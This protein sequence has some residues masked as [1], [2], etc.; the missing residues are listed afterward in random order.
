[1]N[2][3][4]LR[5]LVAAHALDALDADE[6]A[7]V[8]RH[9]AECDD[10]R[11]EFDEHVAVA[12]LIGSQAADTDVP[13]SLWRRVQAEIEPTNVVPLRRRWVPMI[14]AVGA[15]AAMAVLVVV[16]TTRLSSAQ[17]Q[18]LAAEE[19]LATIEDAVETGDWSVLAAM[20]GDTPG[21]RSVTLTGDGD[22][23]VVLLPDGTGYFL[24]ADLADVATD[25][26]Y[27][28]W[29]VQRGEVVSAGLLRHGATGSVFRFD[30][31]TLEG[32]VV[33][34]ETAAGV[35]VAEGPAVSAWFDA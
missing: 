2:H 28:L 5:E 6:I 10:C 32:I 16:Q 12:A 8:E 15:A 22:A 24:E 4:R 11:R 14:T 21:A 19:R 1:M 20:A 31:A 27:Q 26:A 30:P 3:D 23:R 34:E 9:L 33:T 25:R 13:D 17:D 18:L 35:V 7:V 29:V